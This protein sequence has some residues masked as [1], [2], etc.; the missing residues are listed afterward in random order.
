[1]SYFLFL[2]MKLNSRHTTANTIPN[3]A[4]ESN[5][6]TSP[7][8]NVWI[9]VIGVPSSGIPSTTLRT[10]YYTLHAHA[11]IYLFIFFLYTGKN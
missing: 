3:V 10:T 2:K 7:I 11:F 5:T 9:T 1:M 6:T 8:L 4:R